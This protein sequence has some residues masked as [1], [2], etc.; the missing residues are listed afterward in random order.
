MAAPISIDLPHSL[1]AAEA[2]RRLQSR[3]GELRDHIPGGA[4]EVESRWAG[5]RMNLKVTALGQ[6]VISNI[7]VMEKIV[8]LELVLPP[9][10]AFFGKQIEALIRHKGPEL[11]EDK[12]KKE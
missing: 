1:G 5:D 4:A 7:D 12:S 10:L 8:R 6:E 3:I 2:K 9:M 11:L